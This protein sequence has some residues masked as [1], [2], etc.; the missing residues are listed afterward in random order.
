MLSKMPQTTR[1]TL[2]DILYPKPRWCGPGLAA[3]LEA[4]GTSSVLAGCPVARWLVGCNLIIFSLDI[5]LASLL[6]THCSQGL[7]SY[8]LSP[9]AGGQWIM[10]DPVWPPEDSLHNGTV[11]CFHQT[12]S[13]YR[14]LESTLC[15]SLEASCWSV[16]GPFVNV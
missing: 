2:A 15:K 14:E 5:F 12:T 7:R 10:V 9:C 8:F 1:L 16:A 13:L 11:L 4:M 6:P 3:G